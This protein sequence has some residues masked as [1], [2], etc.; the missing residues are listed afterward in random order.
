MHVC[1][2]W[3]LRWRENPVLSTQC[4]PCQASVIEGKFKEEN[5]PF[6]PNRSANHI[7]YC[8]GPCYGDRLRSNNLSCGDRAGANVLRNSFCGPKLMR[9][10][11]DSIN[12]EKASS[13]PTAISALW[14]KQCK[15]ISASGHNYYVEPTVTMYRVCVCVCVWIHT[16]TPRLGDMQYPTI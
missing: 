12:V 6:T 7:S 16:L 15:P 11:F 9:S 5:L 4:L 8:L 1:F 2:K 3:L 14:D 13:T 10:F